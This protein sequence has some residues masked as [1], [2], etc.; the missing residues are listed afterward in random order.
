LIALSVNAQHALFQGT[1]PLLNVH[2][3]AQS[4]TKL[5]DRPCQPRALPRL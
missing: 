2:Y 4:R 3:L 1:Q 5:Q